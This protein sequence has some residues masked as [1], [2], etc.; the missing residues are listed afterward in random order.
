[1]NVCQMTVDVY[2]LT[3]LLVPSNRGGEVGS[4]AC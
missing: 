4:E 2:L 1:M 3:G